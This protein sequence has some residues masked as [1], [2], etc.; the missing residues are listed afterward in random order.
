MNRNSR[1]VTNAKFGTFVHHFLLLSLKRAPEQRRPFERFQ[2]RT[3]LVNHRIAL[4]VPV[5]HVPGN[6]A[7][8]ITCEKKWRILATWHSHRKIGEAVKPQPTKFICQELFELRYLTKL[9]YSLYE[10]LQ[11]A[12]LPQS[13]SFSY[14]NLNTIIH[15]EES[16]SCDIHS[17]IY[18]YSYIDPLHMINRN[19]GKICAR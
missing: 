5:L 10:A 6:P 9:L 15:I 11:H 14:C 4:D 16:I 12:C 2:A 1:A 3:R 18:R 17:T 13:P 7:K 19:H 8:W